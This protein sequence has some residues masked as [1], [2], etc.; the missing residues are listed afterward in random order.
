MKNKIKWVKSRDGLGHITIMND[1]KVSRV[2]SSSG[3]KMYWVHWVEN[4]ENT[5]PNRIMSQ[6]LH[7]IPRVRSFLR[8]L[9]FHPDSK[10]VSISQFEAIKERKNRRARLELIEGGNAFCSRPSQAILSLI[11]SEGA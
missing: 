4:A 10:A 9:E 5:V 7:S 8:Y 2:I 3:T 6:A 11:E 1:F